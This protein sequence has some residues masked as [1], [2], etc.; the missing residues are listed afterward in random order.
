MPVYQFKCDECKGLFEENRRIQDDTADAVCPA[1]NSHA[2]R[3]FS[4]AGVF[5]ESPGFKEDYYLALGKQIGSKRELKE[6]MREVEDT[7]VY[8]YEDFDGEI[9][10]G[11]T[12]MKLEANAL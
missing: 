2:H 6:A 3:K 11:G 9:K 12:P 8:Q 10:E 7:A 4:V 5:M 1:C